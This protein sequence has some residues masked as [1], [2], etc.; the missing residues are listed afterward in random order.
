MKTMAPRSTLKYTEFRL[1]E[2]QVGSERD[3]LTGAS[4]S[5]LAALTP[6]AAG[7]N[8]TVGGENIG[9]HDLSRNI[10]TFSVAD[11]A[12]EVPITT[13]FDEDNKYLA[14]RGDVEITMTFRIDDA[15]DRSTDVMWD[16]STPNRKEPRLWYVEHPSGRKTVAV[17]TMRDI[18]P[19][20]E[21]EGAANYEVVFRLAGAFVRSQMP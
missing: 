16:S 11:T 7:D 5:D 20:E 3:A 18:T 4:R 12:E 15:P 9:A 21:L 2:G 17:V 19:T 8:F 14:G 10:V 6:P 13:L 1:S